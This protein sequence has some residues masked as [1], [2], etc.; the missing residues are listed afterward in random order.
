MVLVGGS[1]PA[2]APDAPA[3][4][5]AAYQATPLVWAEYFVRENGAG[6]G[7][8]QFAKIAEYLRDQKAGSD[9]TPR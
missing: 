4:L 3:F 5:P 7:P 1:A 9:R 6:E 8:K 2:R